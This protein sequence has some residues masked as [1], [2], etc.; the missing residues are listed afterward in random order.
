LRGFEV[1]ALRYA[2]VFGPRQDPAG[3]AGVAS[4]FAGR[5]LRGEAL[6]LFGSGRQTRDYVFVGDV[7]R[8]SLRAAEAPLPSAGGHDAIA[9]NVGTG[10]ERSVLDLAAAVGVAT[11]AAPR[12]EQAPA[13]PG[14]LERSALDAS[15]AE[16]VLGWHPET[17]F[18]EGLAALVTWMRT[19]AR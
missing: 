13:R 1:V 11:G 3:E 8:A 17:K 10:I 18:E 7:A 6:T 2:N 5:A 9:F 15:R 4:I 14:E 12:L 19:E 16:A